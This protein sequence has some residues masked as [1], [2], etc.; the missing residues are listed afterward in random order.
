MSE[1]HKASPPAMKDTTGEEDRDD[2][3]EGDKKSGHNGGKGVKGAIIVLILCGRGG[4]RRRGED[5]GG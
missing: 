4:G 1:E 5:G 2:T 3:Y